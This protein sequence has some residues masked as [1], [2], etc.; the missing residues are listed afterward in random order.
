MDNPI[1]DRQHP[2]DSTIFQRWIQI[3]TGLL[4]NAAY[5]VYAKVVSIRGDITAANPLPV[6]ITSDIE[7]G[8]VEL[9]DGASDTRAKV[10]TV[11]TIAE[12]DDAIAVQAPVLGATT[13][14]AVTTDANGTISAKLRG[15]IKIF[16]DV[17]V[18]A[19]H[20]LYVQIAPSEN[21][22]GSVGGQS[23]VVS[24]AMTRPADT[25]QYS[26]N[27]VFAVN[28]TVSGVT[29]NPGN[30]LCLVQVPAGVMDTTIKDQDMVTL[31]SIAGTTEANGDFIATKVDATHFTIPI[32]FVHAYT[33]G[34]SIARMFQMN[35]ARVA[36]GSGLIN[37]VKLKMNTT[38]T[39]NAVF[40]LYSF[41]SYPSAI[42]DNVQQTVLYA[43][44]GRWLGTFVAIVGGT[45]SG[46]TGSDSNLA[47][48][49]SINIIFQAQAG[50]QKTF[51]RLV[52]VSTT[53]FIPTSAMNMTLLVGVIQD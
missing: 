24:D 7:I 15:L 36:G 35:L 1:Q 31:S 43:N 47:M 19:S 25:T 44:S 17:Y 18:T 16:A 48:I 22:L 12:T 9:K 14:A 50:S 26:T 45:G 10:G 38:V 2:A 11:T 42:L 37:F 46:G 6:A 27:D 5:T 49:S 52:N 3:G 13:D 20:W 39:L 4:Q 33:S 51:F 34:G 21:H 29:A 40:D 32:A 41:D 30:G 53:G 28:I 8:A 23:I